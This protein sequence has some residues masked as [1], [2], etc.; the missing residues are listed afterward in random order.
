MIM[1]MCVPTMWLALM[2]APVAAGAASVEEQLNQLEEQRHQALVGGNWDDLAALHGEAFV[3]NSATGTSL[4]KK[5][6]I[7][8]M[9]SGAVLVRRATREPATVRVYGNVAVVTGVERVEA[10]V[11]GKDKTVGS[12]YLH[13]WANEAQGWRLVARQATYLTESR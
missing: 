6:F 7:G 12:R 10:T 11:E 2:L 8:H 1:K 13:V 4:T 3:Y 9:K 5:A